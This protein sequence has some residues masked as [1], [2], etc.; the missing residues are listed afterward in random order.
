M[1]KLCEKRKQLLVEDGHLMVKGG[2]GAGKTTISILKAQQ[3]ISDGKL[4]KGQKILFL[5]FARSTVGRVIE[6]A[7]SMIPNE[8]FKHLE[9]NTY[10]GFTWSIIQTYSRLIVKH[11]FIRLLPPPETAS[12]LFGLD[13]E[14]RRAKCTSMFVDEGILTFD[15]FAEKAKE[16]LQRIVSVRNIISDTYPYIFVDEFQDTDPHEWDFIKLLGK[17][18]TIIALADPYQRIYDFR[19]ANPKRIKE[20][21][22]CFKP[23]EF[24]FG[25]EN[26]RSNGKDITKFGNDLLTGANKGVKYKDVI[27]TPYTFDGGEPMSAVK[28]TLLNSLKRLRASNPNGDWSIAVLVKTKATTLSIS[29]YLSK[30]S[31]RL[32]EFYHEVMIDPSGPS[33]SAMIIAGL[34]EPNTPDERKKDFISNII[35]HLRGR[36]D[37]ITQEDLKNAEFLKSYLETGTVRG[38]TRVVL[39]DEINTIVE[40]I[41]KIEYSGTPQT[42]WLK[43]RKLLEH[44]TNSVLKDIFEDSKYLRLLNKGALLGERLAEA[45]R[46]NQHYANAKNAIKD[47]LL[48]EHFSLSN[49]SYNGIFVMTLHK[50]KGKEFDEVIIW[51]DKYHS[52]VPYK[53]TPGA[54][55]QSRYLLRVGVTRARNLTTICTP[56]TSK[57]ILI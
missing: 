32:P 54:I 33:L 43:V 3:L 27:V 56:S 2:P 5:S 14:Q 51:E 25:D 31:S 35:S 38:K 6:S 8:S 20:F 34:M 30:K 49:R 11:R 48:Q 16:I 13:E 28:Y 4:L 45:W 39:V 29:S 23:V 18:S 44:C 41:E 36:K 22:D 7:K 55:E 46:Q 24:D 42:D 37:K 1:I 50:S 19:G 57:C 40:G 47:A 12:L 52:I 17:K 10:H 21:E 26:N 15:L 9:I 53:P